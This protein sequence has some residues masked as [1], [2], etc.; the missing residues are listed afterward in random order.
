MR[1]GQT[2]EVKLDSVEN[3]IAGR[4]SEIVPSV[5]QA[6]RTAVVKVDLPASP[7]LRS[8]QFGRARFAFEN[9]KALAAPANAAVPR[10][11]MVWMF[12]PEAGIA[13]SR[14]VTLGDHFG[15]QVEVLS[16]ISPGELVIAPVPAGLAD[17]TPVEVRR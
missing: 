7:Q 1:L 12:V 5:D 10:G 14:I 17:G 4:V 15:N 11:Q 2:V 13:R 6:S 9:R 3:P 16:G 8:G